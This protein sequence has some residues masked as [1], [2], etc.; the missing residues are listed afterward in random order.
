MATK[1]KDLKRSYEDAVDTD[2]VMRV[3]TEAIASLASAE[4]EITRLRKVVREWKNMAA[5]KAVL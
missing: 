1:S 5:S 2:D 3:A 4:A